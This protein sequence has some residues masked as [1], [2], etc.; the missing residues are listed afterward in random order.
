MFFIPTCQNY[1]FINAHIFF[2]FYP[3]SHRL[4]IISTLKRRF[5]PWFPSFPSFIC[6]IP[7]LIP[8]IL[9]PIPCIPSLTLHISIVSTL[10]PCIPTLILRIPII[11]TLIPC[12]LTLIPGIPIFPPW[13]LAFPYRFL[14]FPSFPLFRSPIPHSGFYR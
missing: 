3:S 11:T 9:S 6:C 10:N 4:F 1:I 14:A 7:T 8:R 5:S 12:I 2:N 13:F